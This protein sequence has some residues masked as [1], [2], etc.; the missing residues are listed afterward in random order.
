MIRIDRDGPVALIT[1]D[2]QE[3]LNALDDA[4]N[5]ELRRIWLRLDEED[6]VRA[7]VV[8]G[9]GER[10][11]SAGF[12]L[13]AAADGYALDPPPIGGLTK[14]VPFYKPVIAAINGLAYGGGLEIVLACDLRYAVPDATFALPEVRWGLLPGGGGTVRLP[15]NLPWAIAADVIFGGRVLTAEEADRF[16]LINGVIEREQLLDVALAK[17]RAI[18]ELGALAVRT[19]KESMWRSLGMD[20]DSALR[21]EERMS[22]A[23]QMSDDAQQRVKSFANRERGRR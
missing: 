2:R 7:V 15:R 3:R 8:T 5:A 19:A 11:F 10:A 4:A 12:D 14:G 1:L 9:A 18:A 23:A 22:Y 16:G 20:P 21:F 6:S 13:K 17:A